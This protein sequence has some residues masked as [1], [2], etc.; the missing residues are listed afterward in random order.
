MVDISKILLNSNTQIG[1]VFYSPIFGR[2]IFSS[3]I[4]DNEDADVDGDIIFYDKVGVDR[5][6]DRYGRYRYHGMYF[7]EETMVFPSELVRSWEN[8]SM[9]KIVE[10]ENQNKVVGVNQP[11]QI[12]VFKETHEVRSYGLTSP[13]WDILD[14]L[15]YTGAKR[16][17]GCYLSPVH[18]AKSIMR[19][20]EDQYLIDF[21]SSGI[22]ENGLFFFLCKNEAKLGLVLILKKTIED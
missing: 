4:A 1:E 2:L 22:D 21:I 12:K 10:M 7:S 5:R 17:C 15:V 16:V 13:Q 14:E 20:T 3:I 19:K 18:N 6:F 8:F 11:V 9:K